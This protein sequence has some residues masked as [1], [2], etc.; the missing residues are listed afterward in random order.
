MET[1]KTTVDENLR[2]LP[3]YPWPEDGSFPKQYITFTDDTVEISDKAEN[4]MAIIR[5]VKHYLW[6][7][8]LILNKLDGS[9]GMVPIRPILEDN[10]KE[11]FADQTK[12]QLLVSYPWKPEIEIQDIIWTINDILENPL[13]LNIENYDPKK[14]DKYTIRDYLGE[15]P[16][17]TWKDFGPDD[18]GGGSS[19]FGPGPQEAY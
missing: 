4:D 17:K 3:V 1:T 13:T 5:N 12:L 10:I 9:V 18:C 16:N 19:N 8:M 7:I 15:G 14:K 6:E 11:L 2:K